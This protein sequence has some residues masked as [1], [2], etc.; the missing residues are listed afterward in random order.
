[1]KVVNVRIPLDMH[2]ELS[3]LAEENR[4]T[5]SDIIRQV[6]ATKIEGF[7]YKSEYDW[8][9]LVKRLI[10]V[11]MTKIDY[12][13]RKSETALEFFLYLSDYAPQDVLTVREHPQVNMVTLNKDGKS[14]TSCS[15]S[16]NLAK[17]TAIV[18]IMK[19]L[20]E[21]LQAEYLGGYDG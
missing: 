12:A 6:L 5:L 13:D 9:V 1:M 2:N 8:K 15:T 3:Q 21:L 10:P 19:E 7:V 17:R 16:R 14:Y 4:S 18:K 11:P 20:D